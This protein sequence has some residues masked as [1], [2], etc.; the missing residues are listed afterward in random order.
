[1]KIMVREKSTRRL[2]PSVSVALS[3]IPSSRFH[4]ASLAFSISSNSTKLILTFSVWPRSSSFL[5]QRRMRFAMPQISGRRADQ[6]G[7][8]M[9][10]LELRAID[11]DNGVRIAHQA[12]GHG[13]HQ[14]GLARPGRAEE[15]EIADRAAGRLH[16]GE[17]SLVHIDNLVDG[18]LLSDD[19][20]A[21]AG[22]QFF[23]FRAGLRGIQQFI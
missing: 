15:Q 5:A 10:M 4:S 12:F 20:L 6:L 13:F 9:A 23:C 22:T 19:F 17:I 8:L 21:Q 18:L 11:L 1:M 14:P 16:A 7:D 2:S 3:R